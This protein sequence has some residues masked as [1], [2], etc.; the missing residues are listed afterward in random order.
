MSNQIHIVAKMTALPEKVEEVKELLLSLVEQ[1]RKEEGCISY[2]LLQNQA[3]PTLFTFLEVWTNQQ[4]IDAHFATPYI[5]GA[6]AK[7][8]ALAAG[9]PDIRK[10]TLLK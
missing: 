10:Y 8:P 1:T 4:A 5:Q 3:D 2:Q 6:L 9:P 7:M